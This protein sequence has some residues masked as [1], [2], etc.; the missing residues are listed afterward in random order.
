[1]VRFREATPSDAETLWWTKHAA[2]DSIDSDVYSDRQLRAWKPDGTAV[3]DFERAIESDTFE[4]ILATVDGKDA[5]YGVLN[6]EDERIDAVY[7]NPDHMGQG[8]A[9]SLVA[10]LESRARMHDIDK[11]EI[12]ASLNARSFYERLDY[13]DSGRKVRTL[14][15]CEIEFAI[16]RKQ[17]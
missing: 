17:L 8:I 6:V 11:L 4:A 1:M 14:E 2:I 12:V 13:S 7:V 10:Q 5:G 16:M 15:G 9:T 3:S